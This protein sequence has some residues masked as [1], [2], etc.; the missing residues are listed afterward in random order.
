MWIIE[1][2]KQIFR[3]EKPHKHEI[4]YELG[5]GYRCKHCGKTKSQC[6]NEWA[7]RKTYGC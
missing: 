3:P 7:R 2:L 6:I 5:L 1:K 4:V